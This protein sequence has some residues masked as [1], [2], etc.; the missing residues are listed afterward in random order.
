MVALIVVKRW[1]GPEKDIN[2]KS[3]ILINETKTWRDAQTHC[4]Q[5]YIDLVSVRN[6]TENEKIRNMIQSSSFS[7]FWIGLFNES[8][9]WSDQSNS[10]FR[11]WS[12]NKS[13]GD[14]NCAAVN[15]SDQLYWSDVDCT[16]KLPFICNKKKLILIRQKLT[17]QKALNYCRENYYDLV[18]VLTQEMQ[19]WVKEVAQN[20]STEHVWL[21][22]HYD[23]IQS[24]WFWVFG[25]IICYQDWELKNRTLNED[26]SQEK[27]SGAMQSGG[28]QQWIDLPESSQL[29]FICSTYDG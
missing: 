10:S 22:L 24:I 23:C 12:S 5:N 15:V 17:W 8:W 21:G 29:N 28:K 27:R 16:E 18:S 14:L 1:R 2:T 6:Q 4:R 25:S 11:Y 3:Y 7:G 13:S 26:C 9:K 20:A 19:L